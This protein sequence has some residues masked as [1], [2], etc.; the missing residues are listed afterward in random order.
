VA[1]AA[2]NIVLMFNEPGRET[3]PFHFVWISF[4]LVYG[5]RPWPIPHM[6]IALLVITVTT[7]WALLHHAL[8]GY[9]G[10]E[11]TTEVPLMCA[12]F[13]VMVWHVRRRQASLAQVE[14]LAAVERRR[15]EAQILFVQL[16]SH[17]LRTPITVARG[18]TEL[19]RAAHS[20]PE[21][22]EDTEIVLDELAKL[23]RI[24]ARLLTLLLIEGA[25]ATSTVDL[26]QELTRTLRRW[27]PTADREW[28]VESHV[29]SAALR[30]DR[31]ETALDCLLENAVKFTE[32]GDAIR[33]HAWK[34]LGEI[35]I[36]VSDTGAGIPADDL[37]KVFDH[38]T[39]G[40]SAGDRAGTGLGLPIVRATLAARGGT[41]EVKSE[42]GSGTVFLMRMPERP[43]PAPAEI[44]VFDHVADELQLRRR[45]T[46][47]PLSPA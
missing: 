22:L 21:T 41:I 19:V 33:V 16:G 3:I 14:R 36:E 43:P 18:Y 7:F 5:L 44:D 13:L 11:E 8:A 17:E 37:P 35:L 26:D 31:L 1:F 45:A 32:P 27:E 25:S 28:R 4:A 29:G 34:A 20:D 15:A 9:I 38:F 39:T 47:R 10:W 46:D 23:E 2:I 6:I 42:L 12:L 40:Q 24:T 30:M